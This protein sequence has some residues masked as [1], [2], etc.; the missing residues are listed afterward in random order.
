MAQ[1]SPENSKKELLKVMD[2]MNGNVAKNIT[3]NG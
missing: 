2:V 3:A 1:N